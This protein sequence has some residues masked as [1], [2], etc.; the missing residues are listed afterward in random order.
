MPFWRA[1]NVLFLHLEAAYLLV[2][3]ERK[4]T[5]LHVSFVYSSLCLMHFHKNLTSENIRE[6]GAVEEIGV[7]AAHVEPQR[8]AFSG[9]SDTA[10]SWQLSP[11]GQDT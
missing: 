6:D 9:I 5:E 2:V 4:L 10:R 3:T 1:G 7:L 8:G 11:A